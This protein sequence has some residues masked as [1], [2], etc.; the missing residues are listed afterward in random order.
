M[1][2]NHRM[3]EKSNHRASGPIKEMILKKDTDY[4][5]KKR[6]KKYKER[7]KK[8]RD[9]LCLNLLPG[10]KKSILCSLTIW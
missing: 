7:T 1:W 4:G 9:K 8:E 2:C 10:G 5:S 3:I 6:E